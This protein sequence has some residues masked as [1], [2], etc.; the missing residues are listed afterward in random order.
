MN[1][2]AVIL[3]LACSA[4]TSSASVNVLTYHNDNTRTGQNTNES[5]L[6]RAVVSS[7]NFGKIFSHDV[8]GYVYT[9][10]LVLTQVSIPGKGTRNVVYVATSHDSVYAFDADDDAGANAT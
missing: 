3:A 1:A 4:G 2:K 10:P 8:D 7:T 9:Q 6:T 5:V